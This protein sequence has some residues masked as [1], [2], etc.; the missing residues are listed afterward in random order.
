MDKN[1]KWLSVIV[2]CSAS[3][4]NIIL[5]SRLKYLLKIQYFIQNFPNLTKFFI[6]MTLC[7]G[8]SKVLP[9]A[10]KKYNTL[11][12][13]M[14]LINT[15][16]LVYW[17]VICNCKLWIAL[18]FIAFF[19]YFHTFMSELLYLHPTFTDGSNYSIDF[20]KSTCQMWIQV[21]NCVLRYVEV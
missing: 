4:A 7:L 6:L 1:K 17:Y 8:S 19:V 16:I 9:Y 21:T 3:T 5:C 2:V 15:H 13:N 10:W 18:D 20:D 14:C 11:T 12:Q